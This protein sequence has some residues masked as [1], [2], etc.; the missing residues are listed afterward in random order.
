[1]AS[2]YEKAGKWYMRFKDASGRWRDKV[3]NART[4]TEA[5]RIAD[6]LGRKSERQRLGLE[7][8]PPED[9]GGSLGELLRWWLD[10]YSAVSPSHGTNTSAVARHLLTSSL[11][12][13]PL[14]A[15]T[16]GR[17]E[18]FLQEKGRELSP[19]SLNHLRGFVSRAFNEARKVGR[20]GGTNPAAGV[21]KRKVSRRVGDYLRLEEV[22]RF[23]LALAD[24]WRPLFATALYTGLRKGELLALRKEDVDLRA[25]LLTVCRSWER[26]TTKGGHADVIPIAAELVPFL[27]TAMRLSPSALVFPGEDGTMMRRDVALESVLRRALG[28]AGIVTGYSHVCR[29]KGCGHSEAA[30]DAEARECPDCGMSLW[31]KAQ[32][33]PVRF[34]D[35]RH[36]TAA[37]LLRAGVQLPSVQ[38]ILRHRDPRITVEVYGHLTPDYLRKEVDSL[39]LGL[40]PTPAGPTEQQ[41][42]DRGE[43]GPVFPPGTAAIPFAAS[44]LQGPAG[45]DEGPGI[46]GKNPQQSRAL[47]SARDAGFE[48]AAFGSG[49]QRRARNDFG[50]RAQ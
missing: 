20:Y 9:G 41:G 33:R 15:V 22:P 43:R 8:R 13:L 12:P 48:P 30:P 4:K 7:E 10:T 3:T 44:L 23:F 36:T 11:A 42:S 35:L 50:A 31:P 47:T 1:M 32:V 16:A 19:Q 28:R 49:G 5:R 17:I 25:R 39:S 45:N 24:R 6:D 18:A 37:L 34:H 40:I 21:K 29:R 38:K 26:D 46:I 14:T 27:E 2:V